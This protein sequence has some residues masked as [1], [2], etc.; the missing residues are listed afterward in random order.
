[1]SPEVQRARPL[2]PADWAA[3]A[4]DAIADGGLAAVAVE[5]LAVRLA[6]TKGSFYWHFASRDAL[7][8]AALELWERRTTTAVTE[9]IEASS[10]EPR[11]RIRLLVGE[12]AGI[13]TADRVGPALLASARD[14]LV[15]PVLERVTERRVAFTAALFAEL[16][17]TPPDARRRALLAYSVYLGQA[18]LGHAGAGVLPKTRAGK[19]AYLDHVVAT[20]TTAPAPRR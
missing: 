12:V 10:V 20:L 8:A 14:P 6:A 5:P 16:G 19:A 9:R 7:L 18:Q 15:A 2:A 3:A 4:L 11:E 17:F 1:M 13:A